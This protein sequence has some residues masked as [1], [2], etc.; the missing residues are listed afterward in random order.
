MVASGMKG[1]RWL[2]WLAA[3]AMLRKACGFCSSVDGRETRASPRSLRSRR[4][5]R[6]AKPNMEAP[7]V[8]QPKD[9]MYPE[10]A[11]QGVAVLA[12]G[13]NWAAVYNPAGIIAHCY[14]S[15]ER[16]QGVT[17]MRLLAQTFRRKV[18][19]VH[20]LDRQVSGITLVAFDP[21]T[22]TAMHA[23]LK[24]P[25]ASKVYY[26]LC[27]GSGEQFLQKG[28]FIL[29]RPLRAKNKDTDEGRKVMQE[30]QTEVEVLLGGRS[31]DCCL[32]RAKP[33]TG[34]YH[35][36]RRHLQNISMPILGD[37]Y[38][39]KSTE[40]HWEACGHRLPDRIMLHLQS[41][42]LP[43]TTHSPCLEVSCPLPPEFTSVI[44]E[45][46]SGPVCPSSCS[47]GGI[48][49][50]PE[51]VW[52]GSFSICLSSLIKKL[53]GSRVRPHCPCC[54]LL[55]VALLSGHLHSLPVFLT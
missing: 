25:E 22:V 16:T 5:A 21:E 46:C 11:D 23:A 14:K 43:A 17:L 7:G 26:A 36:I 35:Q 33:L 55:S 45:A 29:D 9:S 32:V 47:Q 38:Y 37:D 30:A 31:P 18:H 2:A 6:A 20:R 1:L 12:M 3:A 49:Q 28:A 41:I 48:T 40:E 8:N 15:R 4:W 19:L 52:K 27:R 24:S 50:F 51:E 39:K 13:P 34:R 10:L 44:R 54:L 42:S 53:G